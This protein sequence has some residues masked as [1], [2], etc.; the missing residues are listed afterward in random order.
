MEPEK[1]TKPTQ[2][3]PFF[4]RLRGGL[5]SLQ[6]TSQT[7]ER[8]V[9]DNVSAF[10]PWL[11]PLIPASMA[12]RNMIT[13]LNF[14]P[15][16]S[17]LGA[18]AVE[19]LGLSAVATALEF[20]KFNED[21][22]KSDNSAPFIVALL[23]GVFY[24]VIILTV[25]ATLELNQ[26]LEVKVAAKAMLSLLSVVAAVIIALR[27]QH[28]RRLNDIAD[29]KV[30][31]KAE[32]QQARSQENPGVST[33]S[34]IKTYADYA[35]FNESRN[36]DGPITAEMLISTHGIPRSTAFRWQATYRKAHEVKLNG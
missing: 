20:W 9:I 36:G 18:V 11:A 17:L 31:R 35:R 21:K 23:T 29:E 3:Q 5:E 15:A 33:E 13:Q 30:Q 27:S 8:V 28:R 12:Y 22:R 7:F 10:T 34:P 25:N 26:S 2:R 19:F 6:D 16:I 14:S 32:R 4:A 1:Q 24:V